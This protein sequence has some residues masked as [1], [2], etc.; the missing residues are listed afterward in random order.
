MSK[1]K[2]IHDESN[3][4]ISDDVFYIDDD[5]AEDESEDII[6]EEEI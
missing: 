6:T 4:I 2:K 5:I 3:D 1:Q